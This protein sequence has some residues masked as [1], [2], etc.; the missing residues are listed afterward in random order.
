MITIYY[1]TCVAI[2][3]LGIIRGTAWPRTQSMRQNVGVGLFWIS[4]PGILGVVT[5][6]V[7]VI[8]SAAVF[9]ERTDSVNAFD[10]LLGISRQVV[11]VCTA[12]AVIGH[13]FL[14]LSPKQKSAQDAEQ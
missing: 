3:I 10:Y 1:S 4:I 7:A 12:L 2:L 9:D 14:F 11:L 8:G 5:A 13:I 6:V